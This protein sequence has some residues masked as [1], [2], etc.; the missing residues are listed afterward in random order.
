MPMSI[1]LEVLNMIVLGGGKV[2]DPFAGVGSFGLAA[3]EKQCEFK[4][5]ELNEKRAS[6]GNMLL[7]EFQ[8]IKED[9]SVRVSSGAVQG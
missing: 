9:P 6:D 3:L 8:L 5:Y 4:G 7:N 1:C 2:L